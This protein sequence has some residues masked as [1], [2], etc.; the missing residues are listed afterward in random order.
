MLSSNENPTSSEQAGSGGKEETSTLEG[1]LTAGRG[2]EGADW[3]AWPSKPAPGTQA[4]L[5]F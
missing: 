2:R 4:G 3:M 5:W 1:V